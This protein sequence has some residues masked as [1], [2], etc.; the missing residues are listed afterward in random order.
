[1]KLNFLT[2]LLVSAFLTCGVMFFVGCSND[3]DENGN[4]NNNNS[5]NGIWDADVNGFKG[6]LILNN[7]NFENSLPVY[8]LRTKGTYTASNNKI[9][10]TITH[11][12]GRY[13]LYFLGESDY[14]LGA[15]VSSA[16]VEES[17]WYSR[18]EAKEIILNSTEYTVSEADLDKMFD[19]IFAPQTA[20]YSL[21]GDILTLYT[22]SANST[23]TRRK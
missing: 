12:N 6:E 7:G 18:T 3:D 13:V 21:N 19:G 14:I 10:L 16:P 22:D 5:L 15:Q 2:K 20:T 4:N 8:G 23:Y 17:K 1:M 11:F 9:T